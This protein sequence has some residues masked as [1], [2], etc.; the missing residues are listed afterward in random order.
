MV[1]EQFQELIEEILRRDQVSYQQGI[2]MNTPPFDKTV[3]RIFDAIAPS[4]KIILR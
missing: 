1:R 3:S 2:V 4:Y